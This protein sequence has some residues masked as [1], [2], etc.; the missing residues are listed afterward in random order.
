MKTYRQVQARAATFYRNN[1]RQ[2][3]LGEFSPLTISLRPPSQRQ[4]ETDDGTAFRYWMDEWSSSPVTAEYEKRRLGYYGTYDIPVRIILDSPDKAAKAAGLLKQWRRISEVFGRFCAELGSEVRVPLAHTSLAWVNWNDADVVR[5]IRV[6]Q[7]L[8][9]NPADQH[10]IRE[11]PI[12]GVDT[13]WMENHLKTIKVLMGPIEFKE[14]PRLVEVRSLDSELHPFG[15]AHLSCPLNE[16]SRIQAQHFLIV[17]NYMTFLALP[18]MSGTIAINGGGFQVQR[19]GLHAP[20]LTEADVLYW[21]D[22]DSHGFS[23]LDQTR[24]YLPNLRS[25]LMDIETA[26]SHAE[27]AIQEP[28]PSNSACTLLTPGEQAALGY[29]RDH[30]VGGC[31]RIE[32]ERIK[33]DYAVA[34]LES[35]LS[36]ND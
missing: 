13:K 11:L 28:S 36:R 4:V 24:R 20:S 23:I 34:A 2:W 32:Q 9:E 5:F 16:L 26:Q 3:L 1:F 21:G 10:F 33:F 30:S 6:I 27:L 12:K 35:A 31:L 8:R 15:L 18:A 14:K 29:L 22:L 17:E 7:W 25:V 19:L